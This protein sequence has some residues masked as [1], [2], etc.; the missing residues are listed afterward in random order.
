MNLLEAI[1]EFMSL[2][3]ILPNVSLLTIADKAHLIRLLAAEI[4]EEDII[5]PLEHGHTYYLNTPQFEEGAA[6]MLLKELEN[7]REP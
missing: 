7:N 5:S 6:D 1:L 2:S 3:D 4:D